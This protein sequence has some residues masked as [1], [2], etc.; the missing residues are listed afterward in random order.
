MTALRDFVSLHDRRAVLLPV[1]LETG[2]GLVVDAPRT[3]EIVLVKILRRGPDPHDRVNRQPLLPGELLRGRE[4][5]LAPL[6]AIDGDQS[7]DGL[8]PGDPGDGVERL[9][10]TCRR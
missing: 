9:A 2:V 8:G 1:G 4:I 5:A 3:T 6:L 7:G 10:W